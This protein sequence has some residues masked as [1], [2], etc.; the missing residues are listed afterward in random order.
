MRRRDSAAMVEKTSKVL[1]DS[2]VIS[3]GTPVDVLLSQ[4]DD[5]VSVIASRGDGSL[6]DP[7]EL[8]ARGATLLKRR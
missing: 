1:A 3:D 8:G 5:A 6:S 4:H 7:I 2:L